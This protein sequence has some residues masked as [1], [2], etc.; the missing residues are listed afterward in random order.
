MFGDDASRRVVGAV[1]VASVFLLASCSPT[2][3]DSS[4]FDTLG[5][6]ELGCE[7]AYDGSVGI[8]E[9]AMIVVADGEGSEF[10]DDDVHLRFVV[11]RESPRVFVYVETLYSGGS[12]FVPFDDIDSGAA[13]V[14]VPVGDAGSPGVTV[15]CWRGSE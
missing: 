4:P 15:K 6:G 2:P 7:A 1:V 11:S 8:V 3:T 13:I 12:L 10:T 5:E 9:K 14:V